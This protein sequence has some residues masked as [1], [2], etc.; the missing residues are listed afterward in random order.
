MPPETLEAL[1]RDELRGPVSELVRQVVIDVEALILEAQQSELDRIH[2]EHLA[3]EEI[4]ET[5]SFAATSGPRSPSA[6]RLPAGL[7]HLDK[8]ALRCEHQVAAV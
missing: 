3:E 4:V 8:T 7:S 5:G 2:A 1:I 6:D